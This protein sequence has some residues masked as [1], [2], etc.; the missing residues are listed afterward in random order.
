MSNLFHYCS[1]AAFQSIISSRSVWLSALRLSNDTSEG[2]VVAQT[3]RRLAT[4]NGLA[5][6][7]TDDLLSAVFNLE[8]FYD[9][10]GFCL[11]AERDLLSQW[12]AYGDDGR[13]VSIGFRMDYLRSLVSASQGSALDLNLREVRYD[14][15]LQ[16]DLVRPVFQELRRLLD[17]DDEFPLGSNSRAPHLATDS[18]ITELDGRLAVLTLLQAAM[19]ALLHVFSFKD[20]SFREEKEWRLLHLYDWLPEYSCSFRAAG[21]RLVPYHACALQMPLEAA[22]AEVVLGPKHITP[23]SVVEHFLRRSGFAQVRVTKSD[24]PYR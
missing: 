4:A 19:P 7:T 21:E 12:R 3:M 13:G 10:F 14:A 23:V 9:G 16:D 24:S 11:S 2:Q 22:I 20:C 17:S 5:Q 1:T 6:Q 15:Q 18:R 8:G